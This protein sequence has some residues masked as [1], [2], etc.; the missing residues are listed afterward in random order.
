MLNGQE[1]VGILNATNEILS[2]WV[3]QANT[4]HS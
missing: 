3:L 4:G 2:T 1:Y